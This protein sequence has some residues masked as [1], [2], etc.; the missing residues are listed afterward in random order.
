MG[1]AGAVQLQN[2]EQTFVVHEF[3]TYELP[4]NLK[5]VYL[6]RYVRLLCFPLLTFLAREGL[7][8]VDNK[9]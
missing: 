7:S 6:G 1:F 8:R 9:I 5:K 3:W 4:R 2:S